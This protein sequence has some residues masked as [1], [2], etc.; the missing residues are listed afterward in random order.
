MI[1]PSLSYSLEVNEKMRIQ[2]TISTGARAYE[3]K[4]LVTIFTFLAGFL[5]MS[6]AQAK[7]Y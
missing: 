7:C 1:I 2:S 3:K 6:L 5:S 4:R